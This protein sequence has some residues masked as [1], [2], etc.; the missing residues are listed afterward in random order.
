MSDSEL[1]DEYYDE[2]LQNTSSSIRNDFTDGY[3]K[4]NAGCYSNYLVSFI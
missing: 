3:I 2:M 1:S 4:S